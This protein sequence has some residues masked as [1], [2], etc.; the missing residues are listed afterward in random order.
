MKKLYFCC[1]MILMLS[2]LGCANNAVL[3]QRAIKLTPVEQLPD[4][5][6]SRSALTG[7]E[8]EMD[9][10]SQL[11]PKQ[12]KA[13]AE[14]VQ[15][16]IDILMDECRPILAGFEGKT[17]RG[18]KNA[19]WLS[20]AG[21]VSG[22]IISPVLT[23]ASP[24]SNAVWISAFSSFSGASNIMS[25]QLENSGMSGSHAAQT[26]NQIIIR[27][28]EQLETV[29]SNTGNPEK[30]LIALARAKSECGL[31]TLT[32]PS[33]NISDSGDTPQATAPASAADGATANPTTGG[34]PATTSSTGE[35]PT[36]APTTSLPPS[37][38]TG[39]TH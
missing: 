7:M 38:G 3:P 17:E 20:I 36:S 34:V 8:S 15:K 14:H 22:S 35:N 23:V 21:L 26:R 28:R 18:A 1:S 37:T 12:Q 24:E 5:L 9:N 13:A 10:T 19:F 32:V 4:S 2:T 29:F 27:I 25:R 16:Q 6:S 33:I 39:T 30:Q 11:T 31:Y